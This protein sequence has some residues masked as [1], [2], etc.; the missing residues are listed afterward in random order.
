MK[1]ILFILFTIFAVY[2]YSQPGV[3]TYIRADSATSRLDNTNVK[4]HGRGTGYVEV[5]DSI[6]TPVLI[7]NDYTFPTSDGSNGQA[8]TT[9]GSGT[10]SFSSTGSFS[11]IDIGTA[12]TA[13]LSIE[14]GT[15]ATS[16]ENGV[17]INTN[18]GTS[19][20]SALSVA[21]TDVG[22]LL[23]YNNS[24]S[25]R[26]SLSAN[27]YGY[28]LDAFGIGTSTQD[29]SNA[30]TVS[31]NTGLSGDL[32][33]SGTLDVGSLTGTATQLGGFT[34]GNVATTVTLGTGVTI[35]AGVLNVA[36]GSGSGLADTW[37]PTFANY[38]GTPTVNVK[39][40][41]RFGDMVIVN[42]EIVMNSNADGD[43][44]AVSMP[45]TF[46]N[47]FIAN[48]SI[49]YVTPVNGR[50]LASSDNLLLLDPAGSGVDYL[51]YAELS[52]SVIYITASYIAD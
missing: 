10:L 8:I 35:D 48:C 13:P 20:R 24:T 41:A 16:Y 52:S 30:L 14:A 23:L 51:T 38:A 21:D 47:N 17:R 45:E 39:A 9:N 11:A 28:T 19:I 1:K 2:G 31:G 34:S 5:L 43:G 44:F 18:G 7:I 3:F 37:T 50:G 49:D 33:V 12:G 40:F 36:S 42:M 25:L 22:R 26:T 15:S 32:D 4:I 27:S 29:G 46:S 6:S